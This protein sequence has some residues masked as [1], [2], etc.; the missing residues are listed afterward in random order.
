MDGRL[1][2]AVEVVTILLELLTGSP[3]VHHGLV[4][5]VLMDGWIE[6]A[7]VEV[8]TIVLELLTRSRLIH[9]GL[10][11]PC[12]GW[13]DHAVAEVVAVLLELL[14]GLRA[15]V[16]A[17]HMDCRLEH[18]IVE[19]DTI[20]LE[21]LAGIRIGSVFANLV[22][23]AA[24][25]AG[26]RCRARARNTRLVHHSDSEGSRQAEARLC[27]GVD[28]LDSTEVVP[29]VGRDVEHLH[30]AALSNCRPLLHDELV[31]ARQ[32]ASRQRMGSHIAGFGEVA[33]HAGD[34][35]ATGVCAVSQP[36]LGLPDVDRPRL[37]HGPLDAHEHDLQGL[38]LFGGL[39]PRTPALSARGRP[40]RTG[41]R[42]LK[43]LPLQGT[44]SLAR[45]PRGRRR[46]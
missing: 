40:A 39:L 12:V 36:A 25:A 13:L 3:P 43:L 16:K 14:P 6:R 27:R 7:V 35:A 46:A 11:Q 17:L 24:E 44:E 21:L 8:V 2:L 29:K 10:V 26:G 33:E 5:A 38:D 37:A 20:L 15:L 23:G 45:R 9:R 41:S 28:A 19:V 22:R 32:E 4:H 34:G 1:E 18:T 42:D 30:G 31:D